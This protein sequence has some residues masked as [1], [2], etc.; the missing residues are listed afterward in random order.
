MRKHDPEI[1]ATLD[2]CREALAK[3]ESAAAEAA[4]AGPREVGHFKMEIDSKAQKMRILFAE[5]E[6][7]KPLM[8]M[9]MNAPYVYD[10]AHMLLQGYDKL[11]GIK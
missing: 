1:Q 7:T 8:F 10:F 4:A 6:D 2:A 3:F 5:S 11:E 9:E